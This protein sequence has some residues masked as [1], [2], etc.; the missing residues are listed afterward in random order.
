[1]FFKCFQLT[2][3]INWINRNI[4]IYI[5][6]YRYTILCIVVVYSNT[7]G[8]S[9]IRI[10]CGHFFLDSRCRGT[11]SGIL[12][13]ECILKDYYFVCLTARRLFDCFAVLNYNLFVLVNI[14]VWMRDKRNIA[15]IYTTHATVCSSDIHILFTSCIVI[16]F[17]K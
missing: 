11:I 17:G 14:C 3:R 9:A 1:M 13:Y 15:Y 7:F 2:I 4:N 10:F 8:Y 16:F 5:D 6:R 12:C